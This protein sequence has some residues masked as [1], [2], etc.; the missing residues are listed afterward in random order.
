V[1]EIVINELNDDGNDD[2][3]NDDY[4][5]LKHLFYLWYGYEKS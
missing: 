3:D 2:F 1:K 5:A 4:V